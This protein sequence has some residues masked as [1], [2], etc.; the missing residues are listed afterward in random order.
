[1][2]DFGSGIGPASVGARVLGSYE[3]QCNRCDVEAIYRGA[4]A[5]AADDDFNVV[6]SAA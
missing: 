6:Q 3:R 2:G 4:K 1:M 5:P